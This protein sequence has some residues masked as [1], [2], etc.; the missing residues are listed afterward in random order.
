[1]ARRPGTPAG[2]VGRESKPCGWSMQLDRQFIGRGSA[3]L[4]PLVGSADRARYDAAMEAFDDAAAQAFD[5]ILAQYEQLQCQPPCRKRWSVHVPGAPG[6]DPVENFGRSWEAIW[7]A[8]AGG[9]WSGG[10][11][12]LREEAGIAGTTRYDVSITVK[13]YYRLECAEADSDMPPP[14][15]DRQLAAVRQAQAIA[16][17]RL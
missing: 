13:C 12:S 9:I 6:T 8:L 3:T 17:Q 14:D 4:T 11:G 2:E 7:I 15:P 16:R 10:A 1:M 5:Y